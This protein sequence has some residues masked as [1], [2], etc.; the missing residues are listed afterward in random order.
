[1]K[2]Q[3]D[4]QEITVSPEMLEQQDPLDHQDQ[5]LI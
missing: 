2:D 1:M 5:L 4:L 3:L